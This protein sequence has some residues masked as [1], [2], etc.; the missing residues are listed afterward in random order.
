MLE[1]QENSLKFKPLYLFQ[2]K[3]NSEKPA[4]FLITDSDK[5]FWMKQEP[6][7]W[8]KV[9]ITSMEILRDVGSTSYYFSG[10][11]YDELYIPSDLQKNETPYISGNCAPVSLEK[12][13]LSKEILKGIDIT[14]LDLLDIPETIGAAAAQRKKLKKIDESAIKNSRLFH[15]N[16][17]KFFDVL[18]ADTQATCSFK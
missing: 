8:E 18:S 4:L 5:Q 13:P 15:S 2:A 9:T 17:D 1:A 10:K 16:P 11:E 14:Q 3:I 6:T 12:I 7:D